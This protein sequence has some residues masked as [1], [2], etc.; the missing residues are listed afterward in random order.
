MGACAATVQAAP[1]AAV[2]GADGRVDLGGRGDPARRRHR[3]DRRRVGGGRRGR[4]AERS[5][6][7]NTRG[8]AS[9]VHARARLRAR[10]VAQRPRARARVACAGQHLRG[11]QLRL[12]AA[13]RAP[14]RG[15]QPRPRGDLRNE[16]R[17]HVRTPRRPAN[18]PPSGRCDSNRGSRHPLPRDRWACAAGAPAGDAG[19]KRTQHG[20]LDRGRH[21]CPDGVGD[22]SLLADRSEPGGDPARLE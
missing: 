15:R 4:C 3:R 12:G 14:R 9:A 2:V 18:R 21:T 8:A 16:R 5:A 7:A 11:G 1:R 20:P 6:S 19:R 10:P 13:C 22:R 17:R